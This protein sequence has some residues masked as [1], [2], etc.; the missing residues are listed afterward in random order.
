MFTSEQVKLFGLSG[1]K[2]ELEGPEG[3]DGGEGVV[4]ARLLDDD[5]RLRRCH[6]V[7]LQESD[8][9]NK[10][11]LYRKENFQDWFEYKIVIKKCLTHRIIW[12]LWS[13]A[14]QNKLIKWLQI[15]F[16]DNG[17]HSPA[18]FKNSSKLLWDTKAY[19][20]STEKN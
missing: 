12:S 1:C 5:V 14:N 20:P 6:Y 18:A 9:L 19:L 3:G 16:Q 13:E 15:K 2:S 4:V 17:F 10:I 8:I 7:A 11:E